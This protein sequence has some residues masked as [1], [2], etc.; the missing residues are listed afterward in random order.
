MY[1]GLLRFAQNEPLNKKRYNVD[2]NSDEIEVGVEKG[3]AA[4][5]MLSKL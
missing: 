2:V 3:T 4:W 1:E 5:E